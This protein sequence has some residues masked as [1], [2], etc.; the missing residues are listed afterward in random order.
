MIPIESVVYNYANLNHGAFP[1]R[2]S[3]LEP[4]LVKLTARNFKFSIQSRMSS[5]SSP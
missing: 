5:L 1:Y 4:I 3:D 2:Y